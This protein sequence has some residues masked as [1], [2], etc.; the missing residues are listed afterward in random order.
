[1][2]V[3]GDMTGVLKWLKGVRLPKFREEFPATR[4]RYRYRLEMRNELACGR[5]P[6]S[7]EDI[8]SNPAN[9]EK[10]HGNSG[11]YN[12]YQLFSLLRS[13]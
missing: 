9:I 13:L 8:S 7:M 2:Q 3:R 6:A 10:L 12:F 5:Q 1:M 11:Q 4:L